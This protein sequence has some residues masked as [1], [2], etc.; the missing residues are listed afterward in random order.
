MNYSPGPTIFIHQSDNHFVTSSNIDG[1]LKVYDSFNNPISRKIR[2][3]LAKI[4]SSDNK[5][6]HTF[7][8][9]AKQVPVAVRQIGGVDCGLF[10]IAYAVDLAFGNDP[11]KTHY[12]Q[13]E[14]RDHLKSVLFEQ[15]IKKFPRLPPASKQAGRRPLEDWQDRKCYSEKCPIGYRASTG[16][17]LECSTKGC[18]RWS[19]IKC[20]GLDL[21]SQGRLRNPKER[22][23]CPNHSNG[24]YK[25][26]AP[27]TSYCYNCKKEMG[28]SLHHLKIKPPLNCILCDR[29]VHWKCSDLGKH[30]PADSVWLCPDHV[31]GKI[32]E[33]DSR[34]YERQTAIKEPCSTPGCNDTFG[35]RKEEILKCKKTDCKAQ[36]H[37][38]YRCSGLKRGSSEKHKKNWKCHNHCAENIRYSGKTCDACSEGFTSTSKPVE[39]R[40]FVECGNICHRLEQCTDLKDVKPHGIWTCEKC[41]NFLTSHAEPISVTDAGHTPTET[42]PTTSTL[43]PATPLTPDD[44]TN[45]AA[46]QATN[47]PAESNHSPKADIPSTINQTPAPLVMEHCGSFWC[48]DKKLKERSITCSMVPCGKSYHQKCADVDPP[49]FKKY[50]EGKIKWTC[51]TCD[52]IASSANHKTTHNE[53]NDPPNSDSPDCN[54]LV[55]NPSDTDPSDPSD[56]AEKPEIKRTTLKILQWNAGGLRHKIHE[57]RE[58]AKDLDLDIILIQETKLNDNIKTHPGSYKKEERLRTGVTIPGYATIRVDRKGKGGAGGGLISYIK[59][60]L[61]YERIKDEAYDTTETSSFRVKMDKKKW[62]KFTNIYCP[63]LSSSTRYREAKRCRLDTSIIPTGPDSLI[64]G[65]FNA[66]STMWDFH[67]KPDKRGLQVE[68]WMTENNLRLLNSGDPTRVGPAKPAKSKK[69]N[70][71]KKSK[72]S[73]AT[74]PLEEWVPK[75]PPSDTTNIGDQTTEDHIRE[76]VCKTLSTPDITL[77]GRNWFNKTSWI[78][79]DNDA[80]GNS[81]HTPIIIDVYGDVN[82][83]PIYNGTAKWKFKN[84]D[85]KKFAQ[86][87]EN[88]LPTIDSD[89]IEEH[90]KALNQVLTD[91]GNKHVGRVKLGKNTK[92]WMNPHVRSI[93]KRRNQLRKRINTHRD[94]WREAWKEAQAAIKKAKEDAWKDT[95]ESVISDADSTKIWR[96]IN[97]LNGTP[98]ANSPNEVMVVGEERFTDDKKKA[99]QF[100]K[101]YAKVSSLDFTEEEK[102]SVNNKIKVILNDP[103]NKHHTVQY[104]TPR[105]LSRAIKKMKIKGAPGPDDIPPSFLKNLGPKAFSFLLN[106][107]NISIDQAVC[108]QLWRD[109]IIIPLLKAGKPAS[110]LDSYRPISLTSCVV[111]CMER[112]IADRLYYLAESKGWFNDQQAGFRKGMSCEDQILTITQA[113]DDGFKA[114]EGSKRSVA[115]L[116]D[117][118]KAF[119]TVWRQKLLLSMI[120]QGV[121]MYLVQWIRGFLTNRQAKVRYNGTLSKSRHFKQGLPQGSVL[122][123]LLFL[124]Y[125][126]NLADK[127]E[128]LDTLNTLFADDVTIL[129]QDATKEGAARKAQESVNVVNAWSKEWK[130]TLNASK[131][132]VGFFSKDQNE[133]YHSPTILIDNAKLRQNENGTPRLLGVLLDRTLSFTA[134]TDEVI[135]RVHSKQKILAALGSSDWGWDKATLRRIYLA[136]CRSIMDYAAIAY[137]PFLLKSNNT[138]AHKLDKAQNSCLR[139]ITR[140]AMTTPIEALRL[141]SGVSSYYATMNYNCL[142]GYEKSLHL[143]ES[144]PRR[145]VFKDNLTPRTANAGNKR[146]AG[147]VTKDKQPGTCNSKP[148]PKDPKVAVTTPAVTRSQTILKSHRVLEASAPKANATDESSPARSH[149]PTPNTKGRKPI[150]ST[151]RP[152][153]SRSSSPSRSPSPTIYSATN[154]PSDSEERDM[155][156]RL[157]NSIKSSDSDSVPSLSSGSSYH[158]SSEEEDTEASVDNKKPDRKATISTKKLTTPQKK[159]KK[160]KRETSIH[161][162]RNSLT[163]K[164]EE[165]RK[166][167]QEKPL[168]FN[169]RSILKELAL[170]ALPELH[171]D[172]NPNVPL[173]PRSQLNPYSCEPWYVGSATTE[174]HCDLPGITSIKDSEHKIRQAAYARITELG[175]DDTPVI[176]TDGSATGGTSKGGAA[177]VVTKKT[178]L[179]PN[180]P[181]KP[182][183]I[184]T[185]KQKGA[186]LTCSYGEEEGALDLALDWIEGNSPSAAVI[187]TDSQSLCKGLQNNNP[188]LEPLLKRIHSLPNK[189]TIQW[190]PGHCGIAGNELADKAAKEATSMDG[191]G[192]P[193]SFRAVSA[194]VRETTNDPPTKHQ[195]TSLVYKHIN[196]QRE[197]EI[198]NKHDQVL[199]AKVRSGH[200]TLFRKFIADHISPDCGINTTCPRCDEGVDDLVHWMTQCQQSENR[201]REYF[202]PAGM[203]DL[204]MLTKHPTKALRLI[205]STLPHDQPW[206]CA[207]CLEPSQVQIRH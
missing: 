21:R 20:S 94:E 179:I 45:T 164:M 75:I 51:P 194:R 17:A 122:S 93:I 123:P 173:E 154:L 203:Y 1:S 72:K 63:P 172:N 101:H 67:A 46:S 55:S 162:E 43:T 167:S 137:Q 111:K 42:Q 50:I 23:F 198:T 159:T 13:R 192:K 132:E 105:E 133:T 189:I 86:E 10:A 6:N 119:D 170:Y 145:K 175:E 140:Q 74:D 146:N 100:V 76:E 110:K 165:A 125:I 142:K 69:R 129:G 68:E 113:I 60:S 191:P 126:N 66:H 79:S 156:A 112:M 114:Q 33:E 185:R 52:E 31:N 89:N 82:H 61:T 161:H 28:H 190:V 115:V 40:G 171:N 97:S 176:Y 5:I 3:Q 206:R 201:R 120:E 58:K 73:P 12:D 24:L 103:E 59:L 149:S 48:R 7:I 90:W 196:Q 41:T 130:L 81:D 124:F 118:S 107:F 121:P 27:A 37:V 39:C 65:D 207:L 160:P 70:K 155:L 78:A 180:S 158:P 4:Y 102:K 183:V 49:I 22:W 106:I 205:R 186:N 8:R 87:A 157:R 47:D 199:L 54:P 147:K 141:E 104:F 128:N 71:S 200:S 18:P 57:L 197:R 135:E 131:S 195:R 26:K 35:G 151:I 25:A 193:V 95:L 38:R 32:S 178:P 108:P 77:C 96:V 127:L 144:H 64:C 204:G 139:T 98:C 109:A 34:I 56:S 177:A 80:M 188:D 136:Y 148:A 16:K 168:I 91:A 53:N 117:F 19:H 174:I 14:M 134:H 9:S 15:A 152:V 116:L 88:T 44:P 11:A 138:N 169:P 166:A 36:C 143:P 181:D 182:N 153:C 84:V 163:A 62:I 2:K 85:W 150:Y 187:I 30:A 184:E 99:D 92:C 29:I 202:G 83:N